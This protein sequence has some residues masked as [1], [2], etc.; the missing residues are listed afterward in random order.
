MTHI[1]L[2]DV[3]WNVQAAVNIVK[4]CIKIMSFFTVES[5][6]HNK[7]T[8]RVHLLLFLFYSN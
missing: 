6:M 1:Y 8:S 4:I 5:H 7:Y 3:D 2:H